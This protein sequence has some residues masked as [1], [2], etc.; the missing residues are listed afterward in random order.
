MSEGRQ[1]AMAEY[2]GEIISR[3]LFNHIRD[4]DVSTPAIISKPTADGRK[5]EKHGIWLT[6]T[7][8]AY[9][10]MGFQYEWVICPLGRDSNPCE[11]TGAMYQGSTDPA[12]DRWKSVDLHLQ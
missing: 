1:N 12:V 3:E 5:C 7:R 6:V 4:T 2:N 11:H 10:S 8:A 9:P